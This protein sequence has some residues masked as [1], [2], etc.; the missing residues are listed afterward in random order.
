MCFPSVRGLGCRGNQR[1]AADGHHMDT[2]GIEPGRARTPAIRA[3]GTDR[4]LRDIPETCVLDRSS[5]N[6]HELLVQDEAVPVPCASG[7]QDG[8]RRLAGAPWGATLQSGKLI[9]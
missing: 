4:N 3:A 2:H 6:R 9:N 5:F 7:Q 8:Q 1:L